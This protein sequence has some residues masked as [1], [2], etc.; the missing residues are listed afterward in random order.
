[1]EGADRRGLLLNEV[2]AEVVLCTGLNTDG[3]TD[4]VSSTVYVQERVL[5]DP[6]VTLSCSVVCSNSAVCWY[7]CLCKDPGS[8]NCVKVRQLPMQIH[9][10]TCGVCAWQHK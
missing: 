6:L 2:E 7:G 1:M 9:G 5:N 3:R 8:Y 4:V 10:M